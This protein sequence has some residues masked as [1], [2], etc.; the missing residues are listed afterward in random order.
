[1]GYNVCMKQSQFYT[2]LPKGKVKGGVADYTLD[3]DQKSIHWHA[4]VQVGFLFVTKTEE[5]EGNYPIDPNIL[6]SLVFQKVGDVVQVATC[7][8]NA[9]DVQPGVAKASF[10]VEGQPITGTAL[11]DTEEEYLKLD[12]L[13]AKVTVYGMD[14]ELNARECPERLYPFVQP[15]PTRLE[16]LFRFL[17]K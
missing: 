1:M 12:S 11:F 17:K 15:R 13:T 2:I 14:L 8:F 10:S 6:K 16:R 7:Y 5:K 3:T 4:K 9:T